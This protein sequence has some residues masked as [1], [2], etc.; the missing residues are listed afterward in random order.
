MRCMAR[1]AEGRITLISQLEMEAAGLG[2]RCL[3]P[4]VFISAGLYSETIGEIG[5]GNE[6]GVATARDGRSG[7]VFENLD[8][9]SFGSDEITMPIFALSGE[10]YPIEI[11]NGYPGRAGSRLLDTVIY[12]KPS[13]WNTYQEERWKLPERVKG[14]VTL[15]FCLNAKVH[16]KGFYFARQQKGYAYLTAAEA[17]RIYGDSFYL[18]GKRVLGIGNNV[19]LEYGEMD[20]GDAGTAGITIW[21]N[22]PL[23]ANEIHITFT[24]YTQ[25]GDSVTQERIIRFDG[26]ASEQ[27]FSEVHFTGKGKIAFLFLPGSNFDFEAFQFLKCPLKTL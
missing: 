8:F 20:F 1:N 21:G 27:T 18:E 13:I 7:V 26:E 16:I 17:D 6:K 15:A 25:D 5:N 23:Q 24:P 3:D 12:Q 22:T 4:Y 10:E 2:R 11:W 9:G 14:I 19:T